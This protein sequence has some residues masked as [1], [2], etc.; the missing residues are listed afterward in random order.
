LAVVQ[1]VHRDTENWTKLR[2]ICKLCRYGPKRLM[3]VFLCSVN[4]LTSHQR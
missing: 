1:S 2:R 4:K 3:A